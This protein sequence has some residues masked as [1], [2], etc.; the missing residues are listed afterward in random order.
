MTVYITERR[1]V[2]I[3]KR[4][5]TFMDKYEFARRLQTDKA[6]FY[7]IAYSYVKNEHDALDVVGEAVYKGLRNLKSLKSAEFF[8]SWM[9]RI[10]INCALDQLRQGARVTFI[11][12]AMPPEWEPPDDASLAAEDQLDLYT[13]LDALGERDRTCVVL[14][15]FEGYTFADLSRILDEPES[16]VKSRMYRS[17]GKMRTFLQKG[18]R[19]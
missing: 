3:V 11:D 10:V 9:T 6:K 2:T 7:R 12:D 4:K 16:T 15:Y 17:L 13:A 1:L 19:A 14:H 18:E 5:K 8:N